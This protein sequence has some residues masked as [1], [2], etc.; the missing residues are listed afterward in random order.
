MIPLITSINLK[1]KRVL[2]RADLNAP[3]KNKEFTHDYRLKA[4]LPTI[5]YI[6]KQGGKVVLITHLGRPKDHQFDENLSTRIVAN[7]LKEQ[8]YIV[9]YEIDLMQAIE[10]SSTNSN[11]ILIVENI[12]FFGGEKE[13]NINFAQ[14]LARLGD[15]YIND[16]FGVIHRADTSLT[17]LAEQFTSRT[18]ACGLLIEKE[19]KELDQLKKNPPQPFF[20]ILGGSKL[21]DKI[22][23]IEQLAEQEKSSRVHTIIAGG[24]ISQILLAAQH[25][26][27]P[28]LQAT[29]EALVHAKKA[30]QLIQG[31]NI[32]LILPTDFL[33]V[34]NQTDAPAQ[35]FSLDKL[36][37]PAICVD[38]GPETIK[39][40]SS[41]IMQAKTIFANGTMG[42]YEQ[43]EYTKGTHAVFT[44][45][46]NS[47]AYRL[48][49]G[50]DAV[51]AT[52]QYGLADKMN[53]LSTGGG[54]TLA[55]LAAH[56]PANDLPGLRALQE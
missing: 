11:S 27:E 16:A 20:M 32:S 23:M 5:N 37:A 49:G 28:P 24:L 35:V 56:D 17:L 22:G 6:Q 43:A 12:R 31:F 18:K 40:F 36:C 8:G 26:M 10:K 25:R 51:A 47:S 42:I 52:F 54:A 4:T 45:C 21:E 7:W 38:I 9:D 34:D 19:M 15:I 2:L 53:Y 41:L 14:L 3:I 48:I 30:L 50:G 1:D 33:V 46:A 55:Y 29:P 44:A 39:N 13:V